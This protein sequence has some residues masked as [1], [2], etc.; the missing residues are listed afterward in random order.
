[1]AGLDPVIYAFGAYWIGVP[2]RH[3]SPGQARWRR[4]LHV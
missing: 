4:L 2:R 3:G 1:M